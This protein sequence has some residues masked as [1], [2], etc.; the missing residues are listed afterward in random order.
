MKHT[1]LAWMR[2]KPVVIGVVSSTILLI[3]GVAYAYWSSAGTGSATGNAGAGTTAVITGTLTTPGSEFTPGGSNVYTLV[4]KSAS[5]VGGTIRV[6]TISLTGVD[7]NDNTC[8]TQMGGSGAT[9]VNSTNGFT[10]PN[11]VV[12]DDIVADGTDKALTPDQATITF[13]NDPNNS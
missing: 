11:V 7:S 10:M 5:N 4:A 6:G 12:N 2:K 13:H 8:D 9:A 3:S 1:K